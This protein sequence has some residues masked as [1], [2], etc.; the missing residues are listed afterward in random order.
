[1]CVF[2]ILIYTNKLSSLGFASFH[3]HQLG[4][5]VSIFSHYCQHSVL[6]KISGFAYLKGEGMPVSKGYP[7]IKFTWL[8]PFLA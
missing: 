4:I 2:F 6:A 3:C 8:C 1:M 5:K 7:W